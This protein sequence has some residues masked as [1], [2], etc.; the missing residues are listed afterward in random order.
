MSPGVPWSYFMPL[1]STW[2]AAMSMTLMMKA[3]AKAQMRLLRT[4]VCR[5]C[6]LEQA[7]G[8]AGVT[9][10]P[11]SPRPHRVPLPPH[12]IPHAPLTLH[13]HGALLGR[14]HVA[15]LL[16][17]DDVLDVLHGEVLA[18]GVVQQP[19]QLVH[20]QLLHVALRGGRVGEGTP[21][22]PPRCRGA[23]R[24]ARASAEQGRGLQHPRVLGHGPGF[25]SLCPGRSLTPN[26]ALERSLTPKVTLTQSLS[27]SPTLPLI[28][29]L[30]SA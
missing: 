28:P 29:I 26:M 24:L 23:A 9:P 6:W 7:A 15:L 12:P 22:W 27:L 14:A 3:M 2:L 8:T 18:E 21:S 13:V 11:P 25:R 17:H 10:T 16:R 4:H 1:R 19:L 5:I 30:T 20:R